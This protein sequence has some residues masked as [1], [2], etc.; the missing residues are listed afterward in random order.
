[1]GPGGNDGIRTAGDD[2][3]NYSVNSVFLL[4]LAYR[5]RIWKAELKQGSISCMHIRSGAYFSTQYSTQKS[6][7][8]PAV[9]HREAGFVP[10]K[11]TPVPRDSL[12]HVERGLEEKS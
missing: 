9:T 3:Y 1:M 10:G 12:A 5:H 7:P 8:V 2:K 4:C 11:G 6:T